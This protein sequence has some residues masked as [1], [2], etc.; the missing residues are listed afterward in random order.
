[1]T[2]RV[3]RNN[4]RLPT[5]LLSAYEAI[6]SVFL[7]ATLDSD[8][9]KLKRKHSR[10][11]KF[12][13][14]I[15]LTVLV[16]LT[17]IIS[18]SSYIGTSLLQRSTS[19]AAKRT[20]HLAKISVAKSSTTTTNSING[21]SFPSLAPGS[22]Y[23]SAIQ[24]ENSLPGTSQWK[25]S[26]A[27]APGDIEGFASST[28]AQ[29]GDNLRLFVSTIAPTFQVQAFR[30]G[31]YQGKLGRLIWTSSTIS[32]VVQ[33]R[34]LITYTTNTT[35]CTNWQVSTAI[36][37]NSTFVPGD[38]L[39]KL[40][41]ST[42]P[43]QYIPL[44]V[45]DPNSNAAIVVDNAVTTWQ[46]YNAYG[47]Y[48]LYHGP[49][50]ANSD[51]ATKVSFDRPYSYYFG[52]GSGDFLGN[53]LPL[54]ALVE[55]LGLNV[56]YVNS[57][58]LD[59]HPSLTLNHNAFVSLGHDEY[60][61]PTMRNALQ[62]SIS[63]GHSILFLG[64]NAIFR[65][66]RLE[67]SPLGPDR[68]EV[69]Y[70]IA[71]LDPLYG[72]NNALVTTNWPSPPD[73]QD[74]S[75]LTGLQYQCNPVN[76]P[77][78]V[79]NPNSWIFAGTLARFGTT[80]PHLIG[81][82]FDQYLPYAPH[83]SNVEILSHSPL[84]CRNVP[85]F[86]DMVYYSTPSGGGVFSTGTNYW[87]VTLQGGCPPF[88]GECPDPFTDQ[89]TTNVL[90][91]FG[92]GGVGYSHP[93]VPNANQIFYHPP[94]GPLTPIATT[95]TSSSTTTSSTTSSTTSTTMPEKAT[96]TSQVVPPNSSVTTTA[97]TT[98]TSTTNVVTTTSETITGATPSGSSPSPVG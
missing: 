33:P 13:T 32:G 63:Q 44:Q 34:C 9:I 81:S 92:S 3:D 72:K 39:L 37:I 53:E 29:I 89:V 16:V 71:S 12:L 69:N 22:L 58:Y 10:G 85:Y 77:M 35:S 17:A 23:S 61:S 82:E 79:V 70:R 26:N 90:E 43:Q 98:T 64:A 49:A 74:E 45:V 56:T 87:V 1:M 73:P 15:N 55:K 95:T 96:T 68:I 78:V 14:K 54:V 27:G 7:S 21:N 50:N 31:W 52:L 25:I 51:R 93:S 38:Y 57:I 84:L 4:I 60:Y 36:K 59:L 88:A 18:V 8:S 28:Y 46:A 75:S 80:I 5:A 24:H 42:G 48:S 97:A 86:S 11:S 40:V 67:P 20:Q 65:R 94:F 41:A 83:P 19:T 6:A 76:A 62:N 30:M 47:G 66:I 2:K 91:A